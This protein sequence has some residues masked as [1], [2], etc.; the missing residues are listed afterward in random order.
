AEIHRPRKSAAPAGGWL[1]YP[2]PRTRRRDIRSS[3]G[4]VDK[5]LGRVSTQSLPEALPHAVSNEDLSDAGPASECNQ[6][7]LTGS[8]SPSNTLM[9]ASSSRAIAR[10]SSSAAS[11]SGDRL[12]WRTYAT[13]ISP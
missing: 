13:K 12:A 7:A 6:S 2:F 10:F 5:A 11:S 4:E 9:V 1:R 3:F 8:R